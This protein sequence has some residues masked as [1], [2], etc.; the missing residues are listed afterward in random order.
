[1]EVR[2]CGDGVTLPAL[3][4]STG[5]IRF[6]GERS[7]RVGVAEAKNRLLRDRPAD[8]VIFGNSDTRPA[9]NFVAMHVSRLMSLPAGHLVLGA[10][11]YEPAVTIFDALKEETPMIFFYNQMKAHTLFDFR[12]CWTLNLSVRYADI[13]RVG[14]FNPRFQPYGYEDLDL[15]FRVLG[16]QTKGIYFDPDAIVTHRHPMTFDDYLQREELLGLMTPVLFDNNRPLFEAL[17]G[18]DTLETYAERFRAWVTMDLPGH[19]WIYK[20]TAE[21]SAR[22]ADTL[23]SG[24]SRAHLLMTLYQMHVPLKRLAFRLGFLRGMELRDEARWQERTAQGL[25]RDAISPSA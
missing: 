8:I 22:G 24:E 9:P 2:L 17:F 25:W 4:A 15:G 20:R 7:E 11:P 12:Q 10:A 16:A 6:T 3:P 1:L 14:F 18:S 13:E 19:A 23:G 5:A 21:W